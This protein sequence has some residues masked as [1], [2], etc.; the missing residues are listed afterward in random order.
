M[1]RTQT[2]LHDAIRQILLTKKNFTSSYIGISNENQRRDLYCRPDG[3][4]PNALQIRARTA[5]YHKLFKRIGNGEVKYIG[6]TAPP[7]AASS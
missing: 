2:T 7:P 5:K 3:L 1:E 4:Y 6:P